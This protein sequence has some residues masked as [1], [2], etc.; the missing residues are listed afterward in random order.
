MT[1]KPHQHALERIREAAATAETVWS[2][3]ERLEAARALGREDF[4]PSP[5]EEMQFHEGE[6]NEQG[7]V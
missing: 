3:G 6:R 7:R 4:L 1:A 2:F 5:Q